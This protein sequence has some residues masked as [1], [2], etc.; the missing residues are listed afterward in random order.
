MGS[1]AVVG[2][3]LASMVVLVVIVSEVVVFVFVLGV[4]VFQHTPPNLSPRHAVGRRPKTEARKETK[5]S[6]FLPPPM[7][8]TGRDWTRSA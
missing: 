5:V 8:R 2:R 7:C 1:G 6:G 3:R 4:R